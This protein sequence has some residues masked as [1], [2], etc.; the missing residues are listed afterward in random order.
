MKPSHSLAHLFFAL[1]ALIAIR[2]ISFAQPA[3]SIV[4][5]SDQKAGSMLVFPFYGSDGA[6]GD[7]RLTITNVGPA[8]VAPAVNGIGTAQTISNQLNVHL[9]FLDST[10]AQADGYL[11]FTKF[12]SYS[13]RASEWDPVT[14]RG[15]LIA[16][17]VDNMGF[18]ISYNG[19]I[20]NAFVNTTVNGAKWLG[21]YGA[22]A[23]ASLGQFNVNTGNFDS[24]AFLNQFITTA[25]LRMNNGPRNRVVGYDAAASSFEVEFQSP[26]DSV[27]QAILTVGL[28]GFIGRELSG[29]A[30]DGIGAIYRN[31]EKIFSFTPPAGGCSVVTLINDASIRIVGGLSN[32]IGTGKTGTAIWNVRA[33]VNNAFFP[34]NSVGL[35]ITPVQANGGWSGIRTL[36]KRNVTEI[37]VNNIGLQMPVFMPTCVL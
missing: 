1:V 23:F 15:D 30:P 9:F 13:F 11:C 34:G 24:D 3:D 28:S 6:G 20:G 37:N 19:L 35:F 29:N 8:G 16:I 21:N 36:H 25:F 33:F 12:Q 7:T 4:Q 31:D 22:E 14:T 27:N 17:V 10:C 2:A 26:K 18:P 32:S 5:V